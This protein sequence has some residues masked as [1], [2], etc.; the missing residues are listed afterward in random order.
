MTSEF[1]DK[2]AY[3]NYNV[4]YTDASC[5]SFDVIQADFEFESYPQQ[6]F[7]VAGSQGQENDEKLMIM[8]I[9]N[10]TEINDENDT[11]SESES[12][13]DL[14][15][16]KDA[17]NGFGSK[18]ISTFSVNIPFKYGCVNR[19]RMYKTS[20]GV[21]LSACM[22]SDGTFS[23]FNVNPAYESLDDKD[24][25]T[26]FKSI[27]NFDEFTLFSKKNDNEGYAVAWNGLIEGE[28][29]T[30]DCGGS[31]H[32]WKS[33]EETWN[34]YATMSNEESIEDICWSP[35]ESTIFAACSTDKSIFMCDTRHKLKKTLI[36]KNAHQSDVNVI[37]WSLLDANIIV[38]GSDDKM[39]N[40][41]DIRT[42]NKPFL[43]IKQ[44][45]GSITSVEWN[46]KEKG[47]FCASS[48]DDTVVQYDIYIEKDNDG[49]PTK[50][51][52]VLTDQDLQDVSNIPEQVLFV[53]GGQEEIKEVHWHKQYTG[54]VI[55][56]SQN[57]L[58]IFR[59][60]TV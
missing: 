39:L 11:E 19:L 37:D 17:C 13:S 47:V 51:N 48:E 2:S 44:H 43:T 52:H 41:W 14:D 3:K 23:I 12:D 9:D 58:N 24:M 28:I 30:G 31:I 42:T 56:S 10:I 50:N 18:K 25:I 8:R 32:L 40:L 54:L 53:H 7:L 15:D 35:S 21:N 34:N 26:K 4:V 27:K 6:V 22:G 1:F 46:P 36:I 20:S 38:S 45:I 57:D 29:A 60:I 5:L 59:T 16:S 33:D 49:I 55:T